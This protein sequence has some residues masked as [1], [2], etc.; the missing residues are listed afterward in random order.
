MSI[1]NDA[2]SDIDKGLEGR[3]M[4]INMGIP[5]IGDAICHLLPSTYYLVGGESGTGKTA[6]VDTLFCINPIDEILQGKTDKKLKIFYYSLEINKERKLTKW[7]CVRLFKKYGIIVDSKEILGMRKNK[8][9]Q[10]IYDKIKAEKDYFEK[11]EDFIVFHD[12]SI[13]PTGIKAK[14]QEYCESVGKIVETTKTYKGKSYTSKK[15]IANDP[16]E[17]VLKIDDHVGLIRGEKDHHEV[18]KKLDLHSGYAV[19]LRNRFGVSSVEISQFNRDLADYNRQKFKELAPQDADFKG[20]GNMYED[21]DTCLA[22]FSPRRHGIETYH[23]YN[24]A[25]L[26]NRIMFGFIL[27]NRDGEDNVS[28]A[29][30]FLGEAGYYRKMPRAADLVVNPQLLERAIKFK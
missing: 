8:I 19:E 10:E 20:S 27:K 9:S 14:V 23:N 26:N 2:L 28:A 25:E 15:Y 18:K 12:S 21:C 6:F 5:T 3:N 16:N 30:N 1:F 17:I 4:G 7:I 24:I 29:L 13:H 22:L 11:V